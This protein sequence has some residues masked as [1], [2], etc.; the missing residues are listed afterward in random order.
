MF[1]F[2]R[3]ISALIIMSILMASSTACNSRGDSKNE[4]IL[5]RGYFSE[6]EILIQMAGILIEENT[7]LKVIF[8][9]S[10]QTIPASKANRAGEVDL[11]V[12]YDGTHLT[13]LMGR[14]TKDVPEDEELFEWVRKEGAKEL[15]LTLT[16][17]FGFENT[18]AIALKKE[19]TEEN[20][21]E[22]ISDLVPFSKDLV[23]GAEHEFFDDEASMRFNPFNEYYN[24]QWADSKSIDIGLKYAA[25]DNGNIDVTIAF[26]TDGLNRKS[27]LKTLIDDKSFFPQYYGAFQIRD[28]LFE[29]YSETAPNLEKVLNSLAGLIDNET[30]TEMNYQVDAE[31]R[32]P[33]DVAKEFL[34]ENGLSK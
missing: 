5:L 18:Y 16:D 26:S 15:G 10:M 8:H 33:T 2:K 1:K 19:F 6:I 12:S 22:T 20:N 24:T 21:I 27:G 34:V 31:G 28:S 25:I 14:D 13:T 23:F 3:M 11:F 4:I 9:D 30:M 29:E 32:N 17:K 7:D